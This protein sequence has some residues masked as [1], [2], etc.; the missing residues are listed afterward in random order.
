MFELAIDIRFITHKVVLYIVLNE[1]LIFLYQFSDYLFSHI[2]LVLTSKIISIVIKYITECTEKIQS[3][4]D[5]FE[6]F[7]SHS[8]SEV[9]PQTSHVYRVRRKMSAQ[10]GFI[11]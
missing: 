11:F 1:L 10:K 4:T 5:R 7:E 6:T 9:I 8:T 3:L 2:N